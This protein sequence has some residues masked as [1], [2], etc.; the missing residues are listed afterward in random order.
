MRQFWSR[1]RRH[2]LPYALVVGCA[3]APLSGCLNNSNNHDLTAELTRNASQAALEAEREVAE[4]KR[5]AALARADRTTTAPRADRSIELVSGQVA[6]KDSATEQPAPAPKE[7]SKGL[8]PRFFGKFFS[9]K[10]DPDRHTDPFAELDAKRQAQQASAKGPNQPVAAATAPKNDAARTRP[11][12]NVAAAEKTAETAAV[13]PSAVGRRALPNSDFS[14]D[15]WMRNEFQAGIETD[16]GEAAKATVRDASTAKDTVET[17][18]DRRV[19]E[20]T[21]GSKPA[22]PSFP[23]DFSWDEFEAKRA[24]RE[25]AAA[26]ASLPEWARQTEPKS[27][28]SESRVV[29]PTAP[30]D[31]SF[32]QFDRTLASQ[33][34][35]ASQTTPDAKPSAPAEDDFWQTHPSV[36]TQRQ[37]PV[38]EQRTASLGEA[39]NSQ[40]PSS[41]AATPQMIERRQSQLRVRALVSEA[42]T[43][44]IRGELHAAYRSALLAAN[45]ADDAKLTFGDE[46]EHPRQLAKAVADQIYRQSGVQAPQNPR[47]IAQTPT[48]SRPH[49]ELFPS[50]GAFATWV[51]TEE[52]QANMHVAVKGETHTE[53]RPHLP[54]IRPNPGSIQGV[55][56]SAP[57]PLDP[58]APESNA[59]SALGFSTA[60]SARSP[61]QRTTQPSHLNPA[62]EPSTKK[63]GRQADDGVQ[64][65]IVQQPV[66][67][68]EQEAPWTSS[69]SGGLAA[70]LG[71]GTQAL[72]APGGE[73]R[74]NS[75]LAAAS[76]DARR[77]GLIA[78][79]TADPY[80]ELDMELPQSNWELLSSETSESRLNNPG[81]E[82]STE[83]KA[84]QRWAWIILSLI[85]AGFS[86]VMGWRV[87]QS[88]RERNKEVA[89]SETPEDQQPSQEEPTFKI[90]RAA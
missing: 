43:Q 68:S 76:L 30:D 80:A 79:P 6:T 10:D 81:T 66:T 50:E 74:S 51:T 41:D 14:V 15:D 70:P 61:L 84:F 42:Q 40:R 77:P 65:A 35:A 29:G 32:D 83:R 90:K 22:T 37:S 2:A 62:P 69:V 8:L 54:V 78:P 86:L 55:W 44:R 26:E 63:L 57:V 39:R 36:P 17:K 45:I 12:A 72:P 75:P 89:L 21:S 85:S 18:S 87:T 46:A 64:F 38:A 23:D 52:S 33:E 11:A 27:Q 60:E 49:D 4:Q 71:L 34:S 1:F 53:V 7:E 48:Q 88:R 20:S 58:N 5:Q 31:W 24:R 82:K 56:M 59:N 28:A 19:A 16:L 25:T 13:T 47:A 3:G 9:R 73:V 67:V